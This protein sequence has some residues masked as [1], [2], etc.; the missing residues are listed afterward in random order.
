MQDSNITKVDR[1]RI[2]LSKVKMPVVSF[3]SNY[4]TIKNWPSYYA[5]RLG[6]LK[7]VKIKFEDGGTY[8]LSKANRKEFINIRT[9]K[10]IYKRLKDSGVKI[11]KFSKFYLISLHGLK[12]K[13]KRLVEADV[14]LETFI[15]KQYENLKV[16]NKVVVDL[17]ANIGDSAIFFSMMGAKKVFSYELFPYAY[18]LAKDN[19]KLNKCKNV[20]L[21]NQA[22]GPKNGYV[23]INPH[24]ESTA[25]S[26]SKDFKSGV[27]IKIVT[28]KDIVNNYKLNDAVLKMDVEGAEYAALL[29][30]NRD[31][32]RRF[33]MMVIECHYGYLNIMRHLYECGFKISKTPIKEVG[34]MKVNFVIAYK[35]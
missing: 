21:L 24:F 8:H 10:G 9:E 17:G 23:S 2:A 30:V 28:L 22:I 33:D 3:N 11:Q 4:F 7:H 12:F 20:V 25:G 13:V 18:R 16:K 32:L 35:I 5:F 27:K 19:L 14:I 31:I 34:D 29:N 26:R 1:A 15:D 6:L